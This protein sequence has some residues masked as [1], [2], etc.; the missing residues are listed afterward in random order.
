M[1]EQYCEDD[2]DEKNDGWWSLNVCTS[3]QMQNMRY[4]IIF[5]RFK[6]PAYKIGI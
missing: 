5:K 3:I 6:Y 4:S 1:H 2:S